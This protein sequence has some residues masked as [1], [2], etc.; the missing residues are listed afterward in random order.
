[1][2]K[3]SVIIP[4]YNR[5]QEIDELLHS[6]TEINYTD[7]EII[8]IE[9][10]SNISSEQIC[11][12]H[13]KKL[14]LTYRYQENKGPGPAR[15]HGAKLAKGEI[16]VFF[17]SDCLI[18]ANYFKEVDKHIKKTDCYGGPDMAH[19]SFN[20]IQKAINYSMT[21]T[22][23]TGGIRGGKKQLDKF[24]PRSFNFGIKT[25][26]FEKLKG[27]AE[28][29]FGEDLDLSMRI[30]KNGYKSMLIEKAAVYH[31]RRNN[32]KTFFKQVYN[33]GIARIHLN[34]RHPGSLKILHL[35]PTLF[36]FGY[37]LLIIASF[38]IPD[39]I[40]LVA[41]PVIVFFMD[42]LVKTRNIKVSA[43]ASISS[44]IQLS[45]YGFGLFIAALKRKMLNQKE[46]YA[47]EENF[48]E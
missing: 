32:F 1:M 7:F 36:T 14:P 22:L 39:L 27:F 18:P 16:L 24:Y 10:G 11:L 21:S 42:A 23:T 15:N 43:T 19:D 38:I 29:R 4:V 40:Y 6:L 34:Y 5:P 30:I 48:Y 8:V 35:I 37:L 17:D 41:L 26:V 13:Q 33:S 3:Y 25:E 31:K 28:L 2:P 47:Y 45:G 9:D 46:F 20:T 12:K 44:L